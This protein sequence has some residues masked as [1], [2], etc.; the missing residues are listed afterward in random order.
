MKKVTAIAVAVASLMAY[1]ANATV[2]INVTAGDLHTSGGS[3]IIP[4]GALAILVADTS[5]LGLAGG[6]NNLAAG[7]SLTNGGDL[8]IQG[9]GTGDQIIM[10]W[11]SSAS[12]ATAGLLADSIT[13]LTITA[14]LA[15]GQNVYVMWFPTLTLASTTI[16]AGVSY[17]GY[18]G[19][20]A[21]LIADAGS[22]PW[23]LPSNGASV[24]I[25]AL[26]PSEGGLTPVAA[27]SANFA[28]VPEPSSIALVVIGL[29]GA[30]GL[31]RRR[32]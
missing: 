28:T 27:L 12:S 25:N 16:G 24:N 13:G 2:T 10:E 32:S 1:Q 23:T 20:A 14:P 17:G 22:D 31:L 4:A 11:N 30:V 3:S 29:F 5:G 18:G 7:S 19:T 9:G 15:T 26:T 21:T 8:T 6:V